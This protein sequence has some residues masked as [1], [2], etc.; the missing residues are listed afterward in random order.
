MEYNDLRSKV[1]GKQQEIERM[2]FN[3]KEEYAQVQVKQEA[4]SRKKA[5]TKQVRS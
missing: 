1:Y 5:F 3:T 2:N 4:R